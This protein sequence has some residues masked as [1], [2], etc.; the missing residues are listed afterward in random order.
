M[1]SELPGS[2]RGEQI[3]WMSVVVA[4]YNSA[5]RLP[6]LVENLRLQVG[7]EEGAPLELLAVD[8][9]SSDGT[10][11]VAEQLGMRVLENPQGDPIN[12]KSL[13]LQVARSRYVCFLDHDELLCSP[14]SLLRK[15]Q[16]M[17]AEPRVRIAL[18]SGYLIDGSMSSCNAYASEFGD[19]FS[20]FFYR[21]PNDSK[22]RAQSLAKRL[23]IDA[24]VDDAYVLR[25]Q[26]T[27]VPIL[28]EAVATAAVIDAKYFLDTFPE[29][30]SNPMLVPHLYSLMAE[31][32]DSARL[33]ILEADALRH[34]SAESWPLV[35]RKVRWRLINAISD[36]S[37]VQAGFSGRH[38]LSKKSPPS[39]SVDAISR[40]KRSFGAYVVAVVPV[41]IDSMRLAVERKRP[42]YMMNAVL[43]LALPYWAARYRLSSRTR[44]QLRDVR[45]GH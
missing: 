5:K 13:G 17:L 12:A 32:D 8:G 27:R 41:L 2:T 24:V 36:N 16:L 38:G 18:T 34:D 39:S 9:G 20:C 29:L 6:D 23:D 26:E 30:I 15:Y 21:T 43:A 42:G 28:C 22:R 44:S 19:P 37:V 11:Q 25:P 4:T 14:R 45:Y 40:R 33:A 31:G 35:F 7:P 3:P 10:V 1:S